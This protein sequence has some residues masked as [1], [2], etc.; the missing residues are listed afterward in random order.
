MS[1]R[2][3]IKDLLT[4]NTDIKNWSA[5]YQ[6]NYG[7]IRPMGV[8]VMGDEARNL[9]NTRFRGM[10]VHV[11]GGQGYDD[12]DGLVNQVIMAFT[13]Y[14]ASGRRLGPKI[15]ANADGPHFVVEWTSTGRD[16]YD[17]DIEAPTKSIEFVI[18]LGG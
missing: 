13:D 6:D 14:D 10:T 8:I 3:A 7:T 1:Y 9:S 18:P 16:W 17:P 5:P 2:K 11:Y 12:L 4:A 15:I